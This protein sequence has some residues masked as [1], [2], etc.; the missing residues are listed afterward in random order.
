MLSQYP[1]LISELK[2][3]SQFLTCLSCISKKRKV[4]QNLIW[5]AGYNILA[6]SLAA[7]ILA[8]I[9][10]NLNPAVDAILMSLSTVI[11]A[12]NAMTLKME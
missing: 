12:I 2:R 6:I 7:G 8:P 1:K 10:F 5:G 3:N 9:G 4:V 11:V